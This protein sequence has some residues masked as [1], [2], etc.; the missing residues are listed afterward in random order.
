MPTEAPPPGWAA[1]AV[2]ALE[3][4]DVLLLK[5]GDLRLDADGSFEVARL[6][7]EAL[8]DELIRRGAP[9]RLGIEIDEVDDTVV[10]PRQRARNRLPHT[11]GQHATYL[12]PSRIDAAG[13]PASARVFDADGGHTSRTHKPYAGIFIRDPGD[14]LSITTFF[15]TFRILRDACAWAGAG[16]VPDRRALAAWLGANVQSALARQRVHGSPY[17]TLAALCGADVHTGYEAVPYAAAEAPLPHELVER[18]PALDELRR[19]CR[20]GACAGESERLFCHGIAAAL[21]IGYGDFRRRYEVWVSSERYDL[22]LWNNLSTLHGA[23]LGARNRLLRPV[24]LS[25][26]NAA[27]DAYEE[28][29]ARLWARRYADPRPLTADDTS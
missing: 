6:C 20:C 24:Y 3:R 18:F 22:V 1:D 4:R 2:D 10:P 17:V 8:R 7:V 28:S 9:S 14:A 23:V 16:E 19:T 5:V 21:G 11:D 15:E 13:F 12:T 29:L 26:P 25:L 27:G